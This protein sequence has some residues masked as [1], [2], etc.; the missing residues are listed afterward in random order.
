M[1]IRK[2]YYYFFYKFYKLAMTGVIKSL[3]SFYAGIGV[4]VLQIWFFLSLY[5]Y[6]IIFINRNAN[7]ELKSA[8]VIV[9]IIILLLLNYFSFSYKNIW[10]LYID[11]FDSWPRKKNLIGGIIVW[12]IVLLIIGNLIFSFYL[13]SGIDWKHTG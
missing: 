10:K 12:T 13:M 6:Y 2:L 7:L 11:E 5:I 3:S 9:A 4:L 1:N 8:K